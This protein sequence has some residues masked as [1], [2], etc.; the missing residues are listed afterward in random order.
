MT[1]GIVSVALLAALRGRR[2]PGHDQVDLE[3]NQFGREVREPLGATI[4]RPIFDDQVSPFDVAEIA[5]P[6]AQGIEIGGV[7]CGGY[8]FEN[9]DAIDLPRLLRA[10]TE[11]PRQRPPR[12]TTTSAASFDR[13]V[14]ASEED[15]WAYR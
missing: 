5:Q 12:S 9:T 1:T 4:R 15:F 8:R 7:L 14:G 2:P 6:F 10:R 3:T 13:L 11:R